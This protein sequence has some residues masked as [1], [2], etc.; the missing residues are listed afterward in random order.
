[1]RLCRPAVRK[2]SAFPAQLAH[3]LP[4]RAAW[5]AQPSRRRGGGW[6][7]FSRHGKAEPF[8]TASGEA[9]DRSSL[10]GS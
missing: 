1:M 9:A 4:L 7:V 2:G 6:L 10:I 3:F 8:R 5:K